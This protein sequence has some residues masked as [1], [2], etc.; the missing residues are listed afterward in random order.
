M[1]AVAIPDLVPETDTEASELNYILRFCQTPRFPTFKYGFFYGTRCRSRKVVAVPVDL[2]IDRLNSVN[3]LVTE[4]W[5]PST[6]APN[7]RDMSLGRLRIDHFPYAS[8]FKLDYSYTV[9]YV[10]QTSVPAH[11]PVNRCPAIERAQIPW[12]G[13][14]LVVRH[15]HRNPVIN[16]DPMDARLVDLIIA[17]PEPLQVPVSLATD[18]TPTP[19]ISRCITQRNW[20]CRHHN[21]SG[22]LPD[23]SV[24]SRRTSL[25]L[26]AKPDRTTIHPFAKPPFLLQTSGDRL[27][28]RIVGAPNPCPPLNLTSIA[29]AKGHTSKKLK[30]Q[31]KNKRSRL[32]RQYNL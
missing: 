9:F 6:Q 15:G 20:N 32:D 26:G 18:T 8:D 17:S 21:G 1:A 7:I 19:K 11:I 22:R 3:D 5:V 4:C 16:V 23:E 31:R 10:P 13:N 12:Y 28:D 24:L 30:T 29:M 25:R 14:I 2:G 27:L